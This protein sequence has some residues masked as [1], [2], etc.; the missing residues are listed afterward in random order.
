MREIGTKLN[1]ATVLEGSVRK[2]GDQLR[3][4]A[5]LVDV[6]NG[7][8][9]WSERFD[10]QLDDIFA[11]QDEIATNIAERLEVT[12]GGTVRRPRPHTENTS[13]PYE[14]YLKGRALLYQRGMAMFRA[15]ECFEEA[16]ALD[17]QYALAHAGLDRQLLDP[18]LLRTHSRPAE[19]WP[20][21]RQA[22]EQAVALAARA[23]GGAQCARDH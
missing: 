19:A 11:I 15:R 8:H 2:M 6:T 3:I 9:L 20:H 16:L 23:R 4:T 1:V 10:R 14:L 22:A 7:Y 17:R 13:R 12:I 21:A 5:Q 18:R